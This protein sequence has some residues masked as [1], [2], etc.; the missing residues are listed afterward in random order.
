MQMQANIWYRQLK[1]EEAKLEA[2]HAIEILENLGASRDAGDCRKL[3]QMVQTAM[4]RR[5]R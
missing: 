5:V 2:S 4:E 1:L 3:L